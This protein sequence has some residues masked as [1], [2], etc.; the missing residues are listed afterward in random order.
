MCW[1]FSLE[2]N[3]SCFENQ[4]FSK[5]KVT[6]PKSLTKHLPDFARTAWTYEII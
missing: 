1:S 2:V 5:E 4:Y 6:S 3:E